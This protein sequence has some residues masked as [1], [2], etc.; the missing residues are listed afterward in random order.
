MDDIESL[1]VQRWKSRTYWLG[2]FVIFL[3]Y[4]QTN[5]ALVAQYVGEYQNLINFIV[6]FLILALREATKEPLS[7]KTDVSEL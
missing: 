1:V 4:L 5:F 6:G 2:L 7:A 3:T